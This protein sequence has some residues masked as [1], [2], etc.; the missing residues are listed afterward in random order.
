MLVPNYKCTHICLPPKRT[1]HWND[2]FFFFFLENRL[3]ATYRLMIHNIQ[4]D[5]QRQFQFSQQMFSEI[6]RRVLNLPHLFLNCS[7][8]TKLC[9]VRTAIGFWAL[10]EYCLLSSS[11]V[12][13]QPWLK[14]LKIAQEEKRHM[15]TPH[16]PHPHKRKLS[17]YSPVLKI[18]VKFQKNTFPMNVV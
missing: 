8:V 18:D 13:L 3:S 15:S 10:P 6:I 1:V 17:C 12:I 2:F 7:Q 11:N 14:A 16:T 5:I 9:A 4:Q